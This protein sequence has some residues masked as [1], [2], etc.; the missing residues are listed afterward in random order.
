[1]MHFLNN[2]K[3]TIS[4]I[5]LVTAPPDC[6]HFFLKLFTQIFNNLNTH[7]HSCIGPKEVWLNNIQCGHCLFILLK[8]ENLHL[9]QP[10]LGRFRSGGLRNKMIILFKILRQSPSFQHEFVTGS[11]CCC[12]A[13]GK[14][15]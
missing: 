8:K 1:M 10:L 11:S 2:F 5:V 6:L 7:F 15:V 3:S 4:E 13:E 9:E 12:T 14:T